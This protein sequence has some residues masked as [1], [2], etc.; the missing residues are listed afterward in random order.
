MIQRTVLSL[1]ITLL[2]TTA[3]MAQPRVEVAVDDLTHPWSMA[4]LPEGDLLVTERPGRLLQL[5]PDTGER[6]VIGNSP[7]VVARG[8]GGLLDIALHPQFEDNRWVYLTWA[9]ACESGSATHLGRGR[10]GD[11]EL[12]DFETLLVAEPC[13]SS[14]RHFGSRLVFDRDGHLY[15]T[16]GD[17]GQRDRSQDPHDLNGAVLRL[18]DDG[19][20]PADNPFAD[21]AAGHPAIYS[22][23]HR[24][25]QGAA[26]HPV[27]GAVWIHEHG[28]RGGDEINLPASG[29]N[30]GWPLMTHGREYHGPEIGP[31]TLPGMV[32]PIH[33]WTPSI[34]P[35]G[36]LFYTGDAFPHWQGHLLVGALVQTHLARL[37]LDGTTVVT[38]DRLLEDRGRRIRAVEQ[39]PDGAILLLTDHADGELLRLTP[40]DH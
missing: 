18:H 20:I 26:L 1:V 31:D 27:T 14:G 33:H 8:Q 22:F 7:A 23:G 39:G 3:A 25:P 29:E 37:E 34:A 40:R 36:M 5:N 13:V 11:G 28:P 24:N 15:M 35:S 4:L 2:M 16:T 12:T 10:L 30:F 19:S 9:G 32:D 6:R 38:E 17:R 21:G